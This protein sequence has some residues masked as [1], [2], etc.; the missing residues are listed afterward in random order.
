MRSTNTTFNIE[1]Y[2]FDEL[3]AMVLNKESSLE[4]LVQKTLILLRG[5]LCSLGRIQL[6]KCASEKVDSKTY[7]KIHQLMRSVAY[8]AQIIEETVLENKKAS[9]ATEANT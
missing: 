1:D 8:V 2:S 9:A 4:D 6:M 7:E 5:A 3:A